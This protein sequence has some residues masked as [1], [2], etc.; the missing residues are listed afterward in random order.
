MCHH[1]PQLQLNL[2]HRKCRLLCPRLPACHQHKLQA[3]SC[4]ANSALQPTVTIQ[5]DS[6]TRLNRSCLARTDLGRQDFVITHESC[7]AR[8][9][10]QKGS[11][12]NSSMSLQKPGECWVAC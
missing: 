3:G 5:F 8:L 6:S 2:L 1:L 11:A 9:T 7:A 4:V 10:R 12:G